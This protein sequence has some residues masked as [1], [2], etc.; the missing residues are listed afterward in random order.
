MC[1]AASDNE[2]LV[3]VLRWYVRTG[4]P[5]LH[6]PT[7]QVCVEEFLWSKQEANLRQCTIECY[8]S[9]LVRFAERYADWLP[10]SLTSDEVVTFLGQH[11]HPTTRLGWIHTLSAFFEW[12]VR[13]HYA[14]ANPLAGI[15]RPRSVGHRAGIFEPDEA[16]EILRQVRSTRQLGFWVMSLFGGMR[17]VEIQRLAGNPAPWQ[18]VRLSDGVIEIPEDQSKTARRTMEI[19]PQLRAWLEVMRDEGVPFYPTGA[20][21]AEIGR[22][23]RHVLRRSRGDNP[24]AA[25]FN[26][27]RR[28]FISYS[29]RLSGASYAAVAAIA[30]NSEKMIRKFYRRPVSAKAASDY[31]QIWPE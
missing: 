13:Q 7:L 25:E 24:P 18:Q 2:S 6:A 9:R 23:R 10:V 31:F 3:S 4:R 5:L 1:C 12:C 17:T 30:G 26:M 15:A 11:I 20:R 14:L 22:V 16:R 27:G 19:R 21:T 28:S 29:L 8:R